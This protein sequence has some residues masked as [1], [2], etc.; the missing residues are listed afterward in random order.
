MIDVS[1]W[2]QSVYS[3]SVPGRVLVAVDAADQAERHGRREVGREQERVA[4]RQRPVAGLDLVAVAHLG[5]GEL[6][7]RLLGEQLDEGHVADAVEAD[8]DG[9]VEDAVGQAALH[10]GAAGPGGDVPVRQGVAL[11]VDQHA[12]AAVA[13]ALQDDRDDGRPDLVDDLDALLL[14]QRDL[15]AERL[16]RGGRRRERGPPAAAPGPGSA[17]HG[18]SVSG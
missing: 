3:S 6:L 9:V 8:E 7:A 17:R 13:A 14:G 18:Y 12:G 15:G 1:I 2:M 4:H 5:E 16:R 11:L 10:H